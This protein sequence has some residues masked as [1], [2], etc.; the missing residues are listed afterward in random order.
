MILLIASIPIALIAL[1]AI[2]W[3]LREAWV[4]HRDRRAADRALARIRHPASWRGP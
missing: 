2:G 1:A 3:A 4:T